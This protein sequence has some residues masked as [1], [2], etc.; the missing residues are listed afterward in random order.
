MEKF[1]YRDGEEL[2]YMRTIY[3]I[4]RVTLKYIIHCSDVEIDSLSKDSYE[5]D[6]RPLNLCT[7][8]HVGD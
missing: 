6:T 5:L 1:Q 8:T 2:N 4:V 7:I 3:L